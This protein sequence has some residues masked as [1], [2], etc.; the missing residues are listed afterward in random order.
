MDLFLEIFCVLV[1]NFLIKSELN[2][3]LSIRSVGLQQ[4]LT[5]QWTP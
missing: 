4:I 5:L 3:I 2:K 1:V